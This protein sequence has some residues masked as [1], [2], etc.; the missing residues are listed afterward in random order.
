MRKLSVLALAFAV[1]ALAMLVGG[2]VPAQAAG[3]CSGVAIPSPLASST[4]L[5]PNGF[6]TATCT[7]YRYRTTMPTWSSAPWR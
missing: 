6:A 1:S 2:A 4:K 5:F 3:S 7:V